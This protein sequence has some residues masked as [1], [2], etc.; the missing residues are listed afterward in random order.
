[1]GEER[2]ICLLMYILLVH[3]RGREK[4]MSF[5][6]DITWTRWTRTRT[7]AGYILYIAA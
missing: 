7:F 1:M 6:V 3:E 2:R 5:A 4:V